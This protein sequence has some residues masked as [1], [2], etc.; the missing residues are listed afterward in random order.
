MIVETR[1][2]DA[3]DTK[4]DRIKV[5]AED[6]TTGEFPYPYVMGLDGRQA[7]VW[8]VRQMFSS[9]SFGEPVWL[10]ETAHG[11]RFRVPGGD[12]LREHDKVA[13]QD[14]MK[15][16]EARRAAFRRHNQRGASSE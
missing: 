14:V 2:L 1:K 12:Q 6:G 15:P 10:S 9:P 5:S 3:T 16:L 4:P 13:M 11:E 7:H 8:A